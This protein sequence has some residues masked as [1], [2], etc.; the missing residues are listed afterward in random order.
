M[1]RKNQKMLRV[2]T[3]VRAGGSNGQ[4]IELKASGINEVI[5]YMRVSGMNQNG[6]YV[7]KEWTCGDDWQDIEHVSMPQCPG[8]MLTRDYWWVGP[9]QVEYH[10]VDRFANYAPSSLVQGSCMVDVP[11]DAWGDRVSLTVNAAGRTCG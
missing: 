6:N 10:V 1:N 3:G 8:S 5:S 2:R 7:S 9:V 4:Q 11:K